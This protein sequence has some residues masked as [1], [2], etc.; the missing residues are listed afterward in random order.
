VFEIVH[1]F[2][3]GLNCVIIKNINSKEYVSI[4]PRFGTNVNKIFLRNEEKL[5]SIIDGN[6]YKD[7]FKGKDIFKGAKLFPFVNRI[8]GGCYSFNGDKY[9]LNINYPEE[10]NAA[11][12]F[13]YNEQFVLAD[14]IIEEKFARAIFEYRYLGT[15]RGYPF[16]FGIEL[17]YTLDTLNGF[18]CE[19]K[20]T[21]TGEHSLPFMD[22]W[23]PYISSNKNVD[24]LYLKLP[25]AELIKV[26]DD[27]IPTGCRE[28]YSNFN[29]SSLI[30]NACFDNCFYLQPTEEKHF[31]ELYDSQQG[32]R[33][34]LWQDAGKQKYNYLQIY[35]PPD[36][37]SIAIEPMTGNINSFN[38]G[39]GLLVL[40][41]GNIFTA[42]YGLNIQ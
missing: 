36:R 31:I 3:N 13:L 21:N 27:L 32:V 5:F 29:N 19:T 35:I 30:G 28:P 14:K 38:N 6:I 12:G 24:E 15:Y 2:K 9:Q 26:D 25:E 10:G 23:H 17:C 20:V 41:P 39:E 33:I 11:H 42:S 16:K 37:K 1:E 7:S 8:K 34:T 22:G 4:V 40:E 18:S